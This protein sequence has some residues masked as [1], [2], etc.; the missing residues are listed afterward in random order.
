MSF[1][2]AYIDFW[3][4]YINFDG[5]CSRKTFWKVTLINFLI[6]FILW[7]AG[8]FMNVIA[9]ATDNNLTKTALGVVIIVCGILL[10]VF[11][12]CNTIAFVVNVCKTLPR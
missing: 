8:L 10:A 3:K 11:Y 2:E 7:F 9:A 6:M 1:K 5:R 12:I 4:N